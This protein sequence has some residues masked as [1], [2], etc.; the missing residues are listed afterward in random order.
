V[1]VFG[2]SYLLLVVLS[3]SRLTYG[4]YRCSRLNPSI[5]QLVRSGLAS[6]DDDLKYAAQFV[7]G[8]E[9]DEY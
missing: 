4:L 5:S 3:S 7:H 1:S 9:L 2:S 6:L 8:G